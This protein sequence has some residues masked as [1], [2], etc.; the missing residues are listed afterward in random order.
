MKFRKKG[1]LG[2]NK[3]TADAIM[4]VKKWMI[5]NKGKYVVKHECPD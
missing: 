5:E 2:I 3:I 4:D 1:D